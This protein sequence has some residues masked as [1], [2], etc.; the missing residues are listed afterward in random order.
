MQYSGA[1]WIERSFK[2]PMSDFGRDV[3]NLLGE[4]QAGIYHLDTKQL[5]KV[6]WNNTHYIELNLFHRSIST[7]DDSSLTRLVFLAHHL[8]I[9]VE[10]S[11]C[12][13]QS[14]KLRFH[15]RFRIDDYDH[16]HPTLDEAVK[17]FKETV[18]LQE[19]TN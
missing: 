17:R 11:P 6:E 18:S 16:R 15:R 1:D 19:E 3:A 2:Q 8:A 5:Y 13:M 14:I 9:R 4:W 10:I 12:N 7:F